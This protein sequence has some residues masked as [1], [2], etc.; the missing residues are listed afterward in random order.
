MSAEAKALHA[1]LA[2]DID[3]AALILRD[4]LPGELRALRRACGQLGA[5]GEDIRRDPMFGVESDEPA[6]DAPEA[7]R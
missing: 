3:D 6:V 7:A 4:F 5:L 2:D 1:V